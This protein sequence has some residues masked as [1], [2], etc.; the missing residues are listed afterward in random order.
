VRWID[1]DDEGRMRVDSLREQVAADR[2]DG[3]LPFLVVATAGSVST[4]VVD[5]VSELADICREEDLWLHADGAYGAPAAMLP[6]A[7]DDLRALNLADSVALDPH[8]WLYCPIEAACTLT[9]DRD[10][11]SDAFAFFPEYYMLDEEKEEGINYY[12][13]GTQNS[14]GFRALK[15]WLTLRNAGREGFTESI[16]DDIGLARRL[17]ERAAAHPELEAHTLN[18]S[19]ATFRYVPEGLEEAAETEAYLNEL[20]KALLAKIQSGG[21][22]YVSNAIVDGKYLLRACIVNFR[23]TAADIDIIPDLVVRIGRQLS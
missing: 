3:R 17:Y 14:R 6:E 22:F 21:A 13:L 19:I 11:L 2:K 16:R 7:P 10:A 15:V 8:K 4:G 23:T 12:Q 18:L 20:N 9:R 5:P 1:T